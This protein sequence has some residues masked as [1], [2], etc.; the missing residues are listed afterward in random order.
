MASAGRAGFVDLVGCRD[1]SEESVR[2]ACREATLA[3][4]FAV[5]A[6][7]RAKSAG[8]RDLIGTKRREAHAAV[9]CGDCQRWS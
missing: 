3:E 1:E 8:Q 7:C 6:V 9:R 2:L 5:D 4:A